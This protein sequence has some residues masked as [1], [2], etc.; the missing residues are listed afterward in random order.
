MAKPAKLSILLLISVLVMS[1][2]AANQAPNPKSA[3]QPQTK[4][5]YDPAIEVPLEIGCGRAVFIHGKMNDTPALTFLIDSGGGS[6]YIIDLAR[7]RRSEERRVG[8]EWR[9][10]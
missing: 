7:A 3:S 10:G 2:Y 6:S 5:E 1:A 9:G 4:H 8:K